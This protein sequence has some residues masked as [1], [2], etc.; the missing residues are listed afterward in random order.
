ETMTETMNETMTETN[1]G[2]DAVPSIKVFRSQLPRENPYWPLPKDDEEDGDVDVDFVPK[3]FAAPLL[4]AVCGL[5]G[6]KKCGQCHTPYCSRAH[7]LAD[8]NECK[9]KSFCGKSPDASV[10]ALR[11]AQVFA[12]KEI[13]SEP[14]NLTLK[15]DEPMETVHEV[16]DNTVED[17]IEYEDDAVDSKVAVDDAFL[18]FQL[19][20]QLNPDQVV[21]Y[22]RVEYDM[23][24]REPLWVQSS[25][26]PTVIPNCEQCGGVR[27]FEFQILSTLLNFLS[28]SHVTDSLDWGS[29]YIY[30]CKHNCVL[31]T[32]YASE[33]VWKQD[34]SA[35]GMQL[36]ERR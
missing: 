19:R 31:A 1:A 36:G 10:H 25:N 4:C 5:L 30:T 22:D 18:Q 28:I 29:L 24:D 35:D 8:W 15:E 2:A 11:Q 3:A 23:P 32:S 33:F 9:H 20:L 14:E 12:E 34:F 6:N 16:S 27:T 7:Q 21:R 26:K 17:D 13:V